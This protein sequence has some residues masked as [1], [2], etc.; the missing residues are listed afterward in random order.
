MPP[1]KRKLDT[2]NHQN[3]PYEDKKLKPRTELPSSIERKNDEKRTEGLEVSSAIDKN[4]Q[5]TSFIHSD[6]LYLDTINRSV[7]D[8]DFEKVCSI[9]LSN[10]NVYACLICGKY[11]QGR[12]KSSHAYTHS[13][14]E[15]HHVFINMQTLKFYVLPDGYEVLHPSLNDIK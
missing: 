9:S 5:Q 13:L 15:D 3:S 11:F 12:G 10:L 4:K 2:P 1:E 7:L 14:H 8:F 6:D